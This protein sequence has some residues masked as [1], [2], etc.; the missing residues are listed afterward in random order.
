L[1]E[2]QIKNDVIDELIS[3][4][5]RELCKSFNEYSESGIGNCANHSNKK[6]RDI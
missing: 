2:K 4:A 3:N 6:V 1:E 5:R